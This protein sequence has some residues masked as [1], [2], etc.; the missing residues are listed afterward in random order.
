LNVAPTK[1]DLIV[2]KLMIMLNG[3][4]IWPK[5]VRNWSVIWPWHMGP[6]TS[7]EVSVI[8]KKI[9]FVGLGAAAI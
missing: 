2:G 8:L 6:S 7:Q 5:E 3:R 1:H 9:N 4:H